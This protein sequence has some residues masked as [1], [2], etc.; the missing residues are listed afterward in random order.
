MADFYGEKIQDEEVSKHY[1][2]YSANKNPM[3]IAGNLIFYAK[4]LDE[5]PQKETDERMISLKTDSINKG[6][7]YSI[8]T[9]DEEL[10]GVVNMAVNQHR[11]GAE[12]TIMK[13]GNSDDKILNA[14]AVCKACDVLN[15]FFN[16][17]NE[18]TEVTTE[19]FC[20]E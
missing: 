14:I 11:A 7:D 2:V 19:E 6:L 4:Q 1:V 17:C 13:G 5:I 3:D 15:S 12:F 10:R 18:Q 16:S 20:Q 8:K 9:M